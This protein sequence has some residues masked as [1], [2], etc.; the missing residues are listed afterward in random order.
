MLGCT[1]GVPAP[2]A[3]AVE[4]S[5]SPESAFL[6]AQGALGRLW[7]PAGH[8]GAILI[9]IHHPYQA[10]LA[11][12]RALAAGP[13]GRSHRPETGGSI[14][15]ISAHKQQQ[16]LPRSALQSAELTFLV[17]EP[18]WALRAGTRAGPA[19]GPRFACAELGACVKWDG[20]G[21]GARS[22]VPCTAMGTKRGK[23]QLSP[24]QGAAPCPLCAC[25]LPNLP[26]EMCSE[27]FASSGEGQLL[28]T[29]IK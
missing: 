22:R 5:A 3:R 11:A 25:R 17:P 13:H 24:R 28:F 4:G 23:Q 21:M 29:G 7:L 18:A 16:Q 2:T 15:A 10:A 27:G 1:H 12:R 20:K 6:Q 14:A 26:M 9:P 8:G 19:G